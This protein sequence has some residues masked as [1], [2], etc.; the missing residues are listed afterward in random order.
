MY[1][2]GRKLKVDQ[3]LNDF[4]LEKTWF[5]WRSF[6]AEN[7]YPKTRDDN[8]RNAEIISFP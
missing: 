2:Y 8:T 4:E 7:I 1:H 3:Q 5:W 6:T